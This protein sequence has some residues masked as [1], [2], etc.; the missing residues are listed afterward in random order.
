MNNPHA[1]MI[2]SHC[3]LFWRKRWAK[4]EPSGTPISPD[5]IATIPN[6]Y[7]TLNGKMSHLIRFDLFVFFFKLFF[8]SF[9]LTTKLIRLN[10]TYCEKKEGKIQTEKAIVQIFCSFSPFWCVD[11]GNSNNECVQYRLWKRMCIES[12]Q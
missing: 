4:Y 7:D 1:H 9:K 12:R 5:S 8:F 11:I 6:L 10:W 3:G 2:G